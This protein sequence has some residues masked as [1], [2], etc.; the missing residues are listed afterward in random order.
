MTNRM[1]QHEE[2]SAVLLHLIAFL[3]TFVVKRAGHSPLSYAKSTEVNQHPGQN[4]VSLQT[5]FT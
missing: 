4:Y 5:E 3:H 2:F 1:K